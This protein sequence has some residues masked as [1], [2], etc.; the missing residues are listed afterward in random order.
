[1]QANANSIGI[2][3]SLTTSFMEKEKQL[4]RLFAFLLVFSPNIAQ[5]KI[6]LQV[7]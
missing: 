6:Y 4:S 3:F 5:G 7:K 1:M 2:F